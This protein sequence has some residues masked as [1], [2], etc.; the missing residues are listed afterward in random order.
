LYEY[1]R[2]DRKFFI[3][4]WDVGGHRKYKL[5]RDMFYSQINGLLLL[6]RRKRA[7]LARLANLLHVLVRLLL[8]TVGI[9]FVYDLVNSKSYSNLRKW[10]REIVKADRT[11]GLFL[12]FFSPVTHATFLPTSCLRL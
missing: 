7:Q 2:G 10:I 4:F 11:R 8:R 9:F 12:L 5:S 3:E 6:T 1:K